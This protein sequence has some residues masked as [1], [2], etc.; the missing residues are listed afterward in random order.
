MTDDGFYFFNP[1]S[2]TSIADALELAFDARDWER[3][4]ESYELVKSKYTWE[5]S[6]EL[7][8]G[9]L[10]TPVRRVPVAARSRRWAVI[11]PH[12]RTGAAAG[13]AF[14]FLAPALQDVAEVVFY[15][16]DGGSS[17]TVA[18]AHLEWIAPCHDVRD[19]GARQYRRFDEIVYVVDG[20]P[21][22]VDVA[23]LACALP[24]RLMLFRA[25]FSPQRAISERS[26]VLSRNLA[27]L[28]RCLSEHDQGRGLVT[29]LVNAARTVFVAD[30][31]SA[32]Y[33]SRLLMRDVPVHRI[34]F[35][36]ADPDSR[37]S[38]DGS[39]L[40]NEL[41][42]AVENSRSDNDALAAYLRTRRWPRT[43]T[44]MALF[45]RPARS[46]PT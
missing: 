31:A 30:E 24:G 16:D 28:S 23:K 25:D 17:A 3:K 32:H 37:V 42:A 5:R 13:R 6:A 40:V 18:P 26:Q 10:R 34:E 1:T 11:C 9:A 27:Q 19:F 15:L 2:A 8:A 33:V 38:Y 4:R 14:E 44:L 43:R 20:S 39:C 21:F 12:P 36:P 45:E 22:S 41:T 35:P 29:L 46:R 7:F